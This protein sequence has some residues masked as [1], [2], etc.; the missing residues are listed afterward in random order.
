MFELNEHIQNGA[1]ISKSHPKIEGTSDKDRIE[2]NGKQLNVSDGKWTYELAPN[3]TELIIKDDDREA[4]ITDLK[5]GIVMLAA[6]QSNMEWPVKDSA[7]EEYLRKQIEDADVYWLRVPRKTYR[8]EPVDEPFRWI[9]LDPQNI[10]EVSAVG[11]FAALETA[12]NTDLPIG[13]VGCY[14]GG[15][16]AASWT[17]QDLLETDESVYKFYVT[18]YWSDVLD[19][20]D[21][22]ED[23]KRSE[24]N[25]LVE[26]YNA[27]FSEYE[28]AHPELN[29]SELKR[30]VGHTP[31]PGPKG[32]K[33][34]LRPSGLY[35]NMA[36]R[37]AGLAPDI[38]LWYQ[39]EEDTKAPDLYHSLLNMVVGSWRKL[40]C[41]ECPVIIA[42]LPGY[43]DEAAGHDWGKVRMAQMNSG[44]KDSHVV[45]LF[46]AGDH[47]NIH[48]L[49][50]TKPGTRLGQAASERLFGTVCEH[51]AH[52]IKYDGSHVWLD[53]GSVLDW[54]SPSYGLD[55]DPDPILYGAN[56]LPIFPFDFH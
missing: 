28:K 5:Q 41:R 8:E 30:V 37:L 7:N 9:K 27:R 14:V 11:L 45:C 20:S 10:N 32:R 42:Q 19:Q 13:L 3:E 22:E 23:R 50:K 36:A 55:N 43:N 52:A 12:K 48:P 6:G 35:E 16:S 29:R 56:G 1:V 31:F 17:P 51:S 46:D 18:D 4:V 34:F 26:Q 21:E 40:V 44:I 25:Q 15:S 24:F 33:D 38:L 53:D 2:I 54:T 47:E 39:G 49:D